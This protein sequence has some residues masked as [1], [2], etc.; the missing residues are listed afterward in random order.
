[1]AE[2]VVEG[3]LAI[4]LLDGQ[5]L[6]SIQFGGSVLGEI[7]GYRSFRRAHQVLAAA[8]AAAIADHPVQYGEP[9]LVETSLWWRP[10]LVAF[11]AF[12]ASLVPALILGYILH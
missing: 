5:E 2:V 9:V 6:T 7:L 8:H 11:A 10:P 1:M 4:R 12:A 3:G